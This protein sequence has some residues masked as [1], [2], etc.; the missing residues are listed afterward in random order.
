[1]SVSKIPTIK[2]L[3]VGDGA[4]G[5]TTFVKR[6]RLGVYDKRYN[7]TMGV[8]VHPI[9][10]H[11]NKGPIIFNIWDV[12]GQE[13]FGGLREGYYIYGKAAIVMFS[14]D[15]KLTF[16]NVPR[17]KE[18]VIKVCGDIPIVVV[19]N[20]NDLEKKKVTSVGVDGVDVLKISVKTGEGDGEGPF[21][22][23]ARH[24]LGQDTVFTQSF[25]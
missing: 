6:H 24:F 11:T 14:F 16:K 2:V 12:A 20:K 19:G 23:L 21:L 18:D 15:S 3:L 4:V 1:M 9:K 22:R 13:K 5:K 25:H 7:A 10:F 8:E 17:W